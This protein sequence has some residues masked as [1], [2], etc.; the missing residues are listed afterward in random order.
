MS[1][2]KK[3]TIMK[4]IPVQTVL[5]VLVVGAAFAIGSM[6]TELRLLKGKGGI[7]GQKQE[8][9]QPTGEQG[10]EV[11][12]VLSQEVWGEISGAGAGVKGSDG[13]KITMVEFT[14]YQCPF[15]S[16]YVNEAFVQLEK[17]YIDTGKI[18]YVLR[19]L[20]LPFHANARKAAEAARCAGEQNKYWEYHG[21]LF[22]AQ[23]IWSEGEALVL[24][25]QYAGELGLD[26]GQFNSCLDTGKF[27]QAIDDDLALAQK[28]GAGGTPT[29]FINGKKLVGAQPYEAFKSLIEAELK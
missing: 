17:E 1:P 29:F 9:V 3:E 24:F 5:I 25:G 23:E 13:A 18:K 7:V 4:K 15:C 26:R 12:A 20:P 11:A 10:E 8:Q 14:D 16:R 21:K 22:E 28:V 2:A 19:D 27:T 6:W